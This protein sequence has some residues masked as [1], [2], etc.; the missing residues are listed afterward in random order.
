MFQHSN[1][2]LTPRGRQRLDDRSRV[3]YAELLGDERKETCV[4][5]MGRARDFYRGL[6]VEVE[7]VMTDDG[8]GCRSRLFN[9]WLEVAGIE[10]KHARPYSPW[11]N[12]KVE[13][14]N[15]T[16]AQEWQSRAPTR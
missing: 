16:L 12:G 15:R 1:S 3:A 4:A 6:G 5:F 13:R 8:P 9:G 14:M 10:R 11:Q 7:R 2:R